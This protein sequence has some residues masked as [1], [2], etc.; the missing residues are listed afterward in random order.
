MII[1]TNDDATYQRLSEVIDPLW[2]RLHTGEE[3]T[4]HEAVDAFWPAASGW[5]LDASEYGV[6]YSLHH[7]SHPDDGLAAVL[8]GTRLEP[9]E[10]CTGPE[11][12]DELTPATRSR[13]VHLSHHAHGPTRSD[14]LDAM[15]NPR[16]SWTTLD[17]SMARWLLRSPHFM[18]E[19][20]RLMIGLGAH[21]TLV[22]K[23]SMLRTDST[24]LHVS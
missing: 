2:N 21:A 5:H 16:R 13:H 18:N 4:L 14:I 23:A 3:I 12:W 6:F 17:T 1:R 24:P 19:P 15:D 20:T 9:G 8:L 22:E 7:L 10:K 11:N